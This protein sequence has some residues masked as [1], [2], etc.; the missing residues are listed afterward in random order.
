ME[1]FLHDLDWV[2]PLRNPVLTV[3]LKGFTELGHAPFNLILLAILYWTWQ[4]PPTRRVAVLLLVSALLNMFLKDFFRDPRPRAFFL[5]GMDSDSFG[6]PSGH[7]QMAVVFWFALA[8]EIRTRRAWILATITVIGITFSRLY[9]GVHDVEDILGGLFLGT[10]TLLFYQ[11]IRPRWAKIS[12]RR[13]RRFAAIALIALAIPLVAWPH[14]IAV[15]DMGL[16]IY[17]FLVG[18]VIGS[19]LEVSRGPLD[20]RPPVGRIVLANVIGLILVAVIGGALLFTLDPLVE[21]GF[22]PDYVGLVSAGIA[23]G[24]A[25]TFA[26]P[27]LLA[28][29][30]LMRQDP[31]SREKAESL[32]R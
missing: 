24:V 3:V 28:K 20:P 2:V 19:R 6:L 17:G 7:A 29:W 22:L 15:P 9:L 13:Q 32:T 16:L 1:E 26:I 25:I 31:S 14:D 21:A 18:W 12:P 23:I 30:A 8:A 10:A 11:W 4:K 5:P 27:W